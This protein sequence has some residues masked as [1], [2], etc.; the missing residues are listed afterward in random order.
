MLGDDATRA[1]VA[2]C[3]PH[4]ARFCAL[5]CFSYRNLYNSFRLI[6]T[7]RR[8]L[9]PVPRRPLFGKF[10]RLVV[11]RYPLLFKFSAERNSYGRCPLYPLFTA[12]SD[13]PDGW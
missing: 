8:F 13:L 10:S 1:F 2:S 7:L 9:L 5:L 3:I 12:D 6:W 11:L 4:V